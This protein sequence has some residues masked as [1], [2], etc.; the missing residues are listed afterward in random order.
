MDFHKSYYF[1]SLLFEYPATGGCVPFSSF[2]TLKL[3]RYV[4][5]MDHFV[6][7]CECIFVAFIFY[8]LI[9]EAIELKKH[10][11]SYFFDAWN[12]FDV[13]LVSMG[14]VCIIFNIYQTIEIGKK[15]ARLI[16]KQNQYAN[17]ESLSEWQSRFNDFVA[18]GV[19]VAW[20][21]V[22]IYKYIYIYI[23]IYID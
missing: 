17:F 5:T 18:V 11:T 10:G 8:Y 15:L 19:F 3:L 4:T 23:Y 12:I 1:V 21:K 22:Y 14:I 16:E 6:M 20:I 2:R 13:I 7:A 9:E